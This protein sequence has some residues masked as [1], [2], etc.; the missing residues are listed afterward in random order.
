[1][2]FGSRDGNR[3]ASSFHALVCFFGHLL[4][5]AHNIFVSSTLGL[6]LDSITSLLFASWLVLSSIA[7][8][9][10]CHDEVAYLSDHV[11][12]ILVPIYL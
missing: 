12:L 11:A 2:R 10:I 4:A 6:A 7:L 1:M 9:A 3:L 5:L 8:G